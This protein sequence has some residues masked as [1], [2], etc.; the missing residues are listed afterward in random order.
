MYPKVIELLLK[1]KNRP[2]IYLGKRSISL[3]DTFIA[4][5]V[6]AYFTEYGKAAFENDFSGFNKWIAEKYSIIENI[7]WVTIILMQAENDEERALDLFYELL[8]EFIS[9]CCVS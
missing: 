4:G 3:L 6:Y 2:E 5:F 8:S 9:D 1:L 7:N